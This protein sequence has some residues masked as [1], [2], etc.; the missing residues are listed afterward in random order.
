MK[1]RPQVKINS[2]DQIAST[3]L[4]LVETQW[5]DQYQE[6]IQEVCQSAENPFFI[7]NL[8]F[9]KAHLKTIKAQLPDFIDLRYACKANP[10]H[11]ILETIKSEGLGVD[12]AS[13]GEL[14]QAKKSGF[15]GAKVLA[16]GPAKSKKY[17]K[18]LLDENIG[19]IV[20][21]STLQLE[22]LNELALEEDKK[23]QVL[24]R[25]QLDW[26]ESEGTSVLGGSAITPFGLSDEEWI[27]ADVLQYK[28]LDIVGLHLFQWGN[29]ISSE[30][31]CSIW[32]SVA[33]RL[34]DLAS[35]LKINFD[36]LDLGGGLG[37][38][39][40]DDER[41]DLNNL[42]NTLNTIKDQ[43]QLKSVILEMGRYISAECGAYFNKIVDSKNVR[44]SDLL[45]MEGGINHIARVAL[46]N[47]SFPCVPLVKEQRTKGEL[48]KYRV[49]G[50][51]CTSL[52][53]LGEYYLTNS[54]HIED[55]LVFYKAG[56]YSLT[57]SMPYFLCHE[58]P[59]LF[60]VENGSIHK[61]EEL[62]IGFSWK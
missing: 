51:L 7:F 9:L 58:F 12:I 16:T 3:C 59:E 28:G 24:L 35:K 5:F 23:P 37:I 36:V 55:W 54:L 39:Y 18:R 20:V 27:E 60:V 41:I 49:H 62:S 47:E 17:L 57:E 11:H 44:G 46:T 48:R 25:V 14:E 40:S 22:W 29:I 10:M 2:I 8:D 30:K 21:E 6:N 31:L 19:L 13:L 61:V 26:D 33:S 1:R 42:S 43:Y 34:N 52:D 32:T 15:D 4:N 56:A 50:P 38:S 53:D 45:V